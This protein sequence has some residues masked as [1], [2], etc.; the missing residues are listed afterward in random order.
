MT[1]DYAEQLYL[2]S[3]AEVRTSVERLGTKSF[4]PYEETWQGGRRC[5]TAR[6]TYVCYY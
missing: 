1:V 3:E 2:S 6:A 5:V 4:T